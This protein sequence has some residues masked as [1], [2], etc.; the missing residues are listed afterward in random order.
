M[1]R[2]II[3]CVGTAAALL[4]TATYGAAGGHSELISEPRSRRSFSVEE[5]ERL[6]QELHTLS[7]DDA[8]QRFKEVEPLSSPPLHQHKVDHMVVLFM[9]NRAFDHMLG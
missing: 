3:A 1:L 9:E 6:R 7:G 2:L 8:E 4:S 5:F